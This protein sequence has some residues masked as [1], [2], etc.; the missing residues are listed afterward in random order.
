MMETP[1][2]RRLA[3]QFCDAILQVEDVQFPIH[4]IILCDCGPFF[5]AL[6]QHQVTTEKVFHITHVSPDIMQIIIDF[7]YTDS[8]AVTKDNVQELIVTADM[9]NIT[10]II[11]ACSKFICEHLCPQNCICIWQFTDIYPFSDLRRKAFHY[12][13]RHF[14]GVVN[15]EEYLQLSLQE[16]TEI[17]GKDEVNVRNE[18]TLFDVILRWITHIP[19]EREQHMAVLLSKVR[20]GRTSIEYIE[21]NVMTNELVKFNP[22]CLEIVN[23]SFKILWSFTTHIHKPFKSCLRDTPARPRLPDSIIMVSGGK[24][25]STVSCGI[26]MY[27]PLVD[28]WIISRDKLKDPRAHHGTVFLDGYVYFVGGSDLLEIL[29][30]VVR[31][32]LRTHTWQEVMYMHYRRSR[33][34]VTK[35]NGFIYAFGGTDGY[36]WLNTAERYC[37]KSNQWTL[38]APMILGRRSASCAA[39]DGKI[40]VCGGL[41][42]HYS[43]KTAECYDPET[44]Q[45][46]MIG[47]MNI[48]RRQHRVVAYKN[49]IFAVGGIR[50]VHPLQS[51]ETYEPQTDTWILLCPMMISRRNFCLEVIDDK[52]Y[53]VGG[54]NVRKRSYHAEV[55]DPETD[56]WSSISDSKTSY[57]GMS[58]CVVSGIPNMVDFAFPRDSLP[59]FEKSEKLSHHFN[60]K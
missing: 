9:F 30:S 12:I 57:D 13:M 58:S 51:I 21:N 11:E 14:E 38:I 1:N 53:V 37:P 34:S 43:T 23:R 26:E 59:L 41:I 7:A 47:R 31:L 46:T 18:R 22:E 28:R 60:T 24:N 27:D 20:L 52:F 17:L 54:S 40:Y 35:L 19:K 4:R 39:L 48:S 50:G 33:V 5:Q 15:C 44:D 3:G 8:L 36:I 29:N 2:E 32:D 55:Y 45:W 10:S 25:F 16:L 6:F 56:I 42:R 49:Q